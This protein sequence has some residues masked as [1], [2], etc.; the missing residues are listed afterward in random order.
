MN[1]KVKTLSKEIE[2]MNRHQIEILGRRMWEEGE[3]I[4]EMLVQ[5]NKLDN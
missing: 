4:G 2:N 3:G 1:G 5:V